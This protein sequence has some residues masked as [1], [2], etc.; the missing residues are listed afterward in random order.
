[1][2]EAIGRILSA[3]EELGLSEKTM[4]I[5]FSDNGGHGGM[6]N[7][8][9]LK[10]MKGMLYEGGIREPLFMKWPGQIEQGT[11]SDEPVIGLDLHATILDITQTDVKS[12]LDGVS[13]LPVFKNEPLE[14]RSLYWHFPAYL[15]MMNSKKK[16]WKSHWRTSPASAMRKGDWKYIYF[17]EEKKGELYNLT[18]DIGESKDLSTNNR[19]KADQMH[20]NL[21]NWLKSVDA[22]IEFE[23]NPD[24]DP[25]PIK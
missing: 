4:V 3:L 22:E 7:S 18:E 9:P 5:F 24:Y 20:L 13:L 6:T 23:Q 14:E 1:M 11:Y 10:G 17:Y 2:D 16:E 15:E 25:D 19:Q 12:K 21:F 8:F